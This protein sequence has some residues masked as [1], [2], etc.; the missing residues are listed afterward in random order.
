MTKD[1]RILQ[2][3]NELKELEGKYQSLLNRQRALEE[4]KELDV[5]EKLDLLRAREQLNFYRRMYEMNETMKKSNVFTKQ[6]VSDNEEVRELKKKLKECQIT[7]EYLKAIINEKLYLNSDDELDN[8]ILYRI[9]M[10][11]GKDVEANTQSKI[12]DE[13]R[14]RIRQLREEGYSMRR[15]AKMEQVS[16]GVVHKIIHAG[17]ISNITESIDVKE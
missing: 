1:E 17:K 12:D 8:S 15:I 10:E 7:N 11:A 2:L 4:Q 14:A 9:F 13:T 6:R 3:E 5:T 16:V